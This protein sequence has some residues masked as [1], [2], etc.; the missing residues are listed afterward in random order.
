MKISLLL[1]K[2]ER[3]EII[4]LLKY[5]LELGRL[6]KKLTLVIEINQEM[7]MGKIISIIS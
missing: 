5:H 1:S 2:A 3:L 6:L 4:I 7:K